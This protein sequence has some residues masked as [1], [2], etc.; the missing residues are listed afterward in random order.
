MPK[1]RS[2]ISYLVLAVT[3]VACTNRCSETELEGGEAWQT[4]YKSMAL[5]ESVPQ[6]P[7]QALASFRYPSNINVE[8]VAAEPLIGDPVAM[9]WDEN[10]NLYVVE[11][12]GFMLDTYG[13]GETDPLGRVVKLVDEDGD[14]QMDRSEVILDKLVNPRAL[15]VLN[16]GLLVAEPPN[17][18][19]CPGASG[20]FDCANKARLGDYGNGNPDDVE[21]DEN[22]LLP[23]VDGWLYSAKSD[24]RRRLIGGELKVEKTAFRGQWGLSE[25]RQGRL[26]SN[27]NSTLAQVDLLPAEYYAHYPYSSLGEDTAAGIGELLLNDQQVYS[28]RPNASVN[29]AYSEGVLRDDDRLNSATAASGLSVYQGTQLPQEWQ[30]HVFVPEPAGNLVA[31][32]KVSFDGLAHHTEH[33][34]YDDPDWGTRDF[35]SSTDERF[36]PVDVRQ[37]P[38]GA[39]YIIDMYRGVIQHRQ[40]LTEQLRQQSIERG[41]VQPVGMGRI[42]RVSSKDAAQEQLPKLHTAEA[43]IAGLHSENSWVQR[44][45]G[46]LLAAAKHRAELAELALLEQP[47]H[48]VNRLLW[49]KHNTGTLRGEELL[50]LLQQPSAALIT[51]IH[52]APDYL[53]APEFLGAGVEAGVATATTDEQALY[54]MAA[55]ARYGCEACVEKGREILADHINSPIHRRVWLSLRAGHAKEE[56]AHWLRIESLEKAELDPLLRNLAMGAVLEAKDSQGSGS[57]AADELF[58]DLDGRIPSL[59]SWQQVALMR[60]IASVSRLENFERLKLSGEP[61]LIVILENS[62]DE[63]VR[64]ALHAARSVF[65]WPGDSY[66]AGLSPLSPEDKVRLER[67]KALYAAQCAACHQAEGQ[68]Q[69][70]LAP[71][72]A[73]SEWVSGPAEWLSRI[74]LHGVSGPITVNGQEWDG[75]MPGHGHLEGFDDDSIAG[76]MTYM[77]RSW[78]NVAHAVKPE[79]VREVRLAEQARSTAWTVAELEKIEVK[80]PFSKYNGV[81]KIPFMP[82]TMTVKAMP[83]GIHMDT[84]QG[85]MFLQPEADGSFNVPSEGIR[86]EFIETDSGDIELALER[87]KDKIRMSR[88]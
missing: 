65:T 13:T 77:R 5:E 14:G 68:G 59:L 60:G 19:L 51:A 32:L 62:V 36:R 53:S 30:G 61:A 67:G 49:L 78:G 79:E 63:D 2:V 8:L 9:E 81:Y 24:L 16:E 4:R 28:I 7:T 35:L 29:R 10:G 20:E 25:D 57:G 55:L 64:A 46:R 43:L 52:L 3:V 83:N 74:I 75:V 12:R 48:A 88:K 1:L 45:A 44:T 84:P 37:G 87:G 72:L 85:S 39:L 80:S 69:T 73:E 71:M 33:V 50:T 22:R 23:A 26:Y 56:L 82:V 18:W 41:L 11:M 76:L 66:V 34:T 21:H 38:D 47:E 17:L 86:F 6:S 31:Q 42:W 15:A 70:G 58:L 27:N 40:F 54:T